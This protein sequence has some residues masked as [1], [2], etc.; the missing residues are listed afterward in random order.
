VVHIPFP[1]QRISSPDTGIC[2]GK[3]SVAEYLIQ[4]QGFQQVHLVR[5]VAGLDSWNGQFSND[6][7]Q[8]FCFVEPEPLLDFVTRRWNGRWLTTDVWNEEIVDVYSKRPF[9]FLISVDA[10]AMVRWE[11]LKKK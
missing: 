11:R 6:A 2:A 5:S 10:P 7:N 3:S 4:K 9:F 1:V 8:G